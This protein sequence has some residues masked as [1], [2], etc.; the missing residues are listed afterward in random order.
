MNSGWNQFFHALLAWI[1]NSQKSWPPRTSECDFICKCH[2]LRGSHIGLG[3]ALNQMTIVLLRRPCEETDTCSEEND[4]WW[5]RRRWEWCV[6]KPR[7]TRDCR[8]SPEAGRSKARTDSAL[9]PLEEACPCW[10]LDLRPS[11]SYN[12][13]S[14]SVVLGDPV[15]VFCYGNPSKHTCQIVF[16]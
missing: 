6:Y 1:V 3:W 9:Q 8:Q 11:S 12:C 16:Y 2:F 14:T 10:H 15:F 4:M 7:T 5:L 13:E